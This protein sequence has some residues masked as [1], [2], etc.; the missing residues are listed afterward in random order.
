M[1]EQ[2]AARQK[3]TY[4]TAET[5]QQAADPQ[6]LK[7]SHQRRSGHAHRKTPM[8]IAIEDP[9]EHLDDVLQQYRPLAK[10]IIHAEVLGKPM[11]LRPMGSHDFT[12]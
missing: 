11:A 1:A 4:K 5:F 8:A 6:S 9:L 12:Y 10:A 3:R 7:T 2:L